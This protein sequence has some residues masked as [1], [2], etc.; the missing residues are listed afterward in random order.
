[1][2]ARLLAA[3]VSLCGAATLLGQTAAKPTPAAPSRVYSIVG[4]TVH[5]V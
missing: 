3:A 1:M 5:P 2:K 4:A